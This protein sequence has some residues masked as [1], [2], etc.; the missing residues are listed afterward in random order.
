[1]LIVLARRSSA[2]IPC[3]SLL[4]RHHQRVAEQ[5]GPRDGE[6]ELGAGLAVGRD[7]AGV[8]VGGAGDEA[9]AEQAQESRLFRIGRGRR[10]DPPCCYRH[11]M[12]SAP[13][14]EKARTE[15]RAFPD[16]EQRTNRG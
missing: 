16:D 14:G 8:I 12:F 7:P 2:T 10:T 4:D 1:M 15:L 3:S 5:H 6:T 13:L 9:R 11:A